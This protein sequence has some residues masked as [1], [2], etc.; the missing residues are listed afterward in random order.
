MTAVVT[1]GE[2]AP[3]PLRS[4]RRLV[5][6]LIGGALVSKLLGF[7]REL[8]MAQVLG[9]SLIADGFRGA[10]TAILLPLAFLQNESV[11]AIM[12]PGQRDALIRGDAPV[13]LASLTMALTLIAVLLTIAVEAAG[14]RWIDAVV[15]GFV[16]EGRDMTLAFVRIMAL[17]MPASVALNCLAA[18]EIAL[19]RSR[20][21]NLRAGLL[22]VCVMLGLVLLMLTGRVDVLAWAFTLSFNAL[23]AWGIWTLWRE[24]QFSFAG[25]RPSLVL[26]AGIDFLRRLR[27]LFALPFVEQLNVWVERLLT[28][29]LGTG[30]VAS[31]DYARTLTDSANMLISQ[32]VGLGVLSTH[33]PE[34]DRARIERI[35]APVLALALPTSMFVVVFAPEIVR[36]VF[37]RGAF[38]EQA[39][40]LTSHALQGIAAGLWASTLGW[41]LLRTL[42]STGR[43]LHAALILIAAHALNIG[44][45]LATASLQQSSGAGVLIIGTGEAVRSLVL[46]GGTLLA[47]SCRRRIAMLILIAAGPALAML[48]AGLLI[49]EEIAGTLPRLAAGGAACAA[50]IA[51][52]ALLLMPATCRAVAVHVRNR[53]FSAGRS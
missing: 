9:A 37:F 29:R 34:D 38:T 44:F 46:L 48:G 36:L 28:S 49:R 41:I 5:A 43:N 47:I 17:G 6:V 45:N 8:L 53:V 35:A 11:P 31:L 33:P 14:I 16:P 15:G 1:D 18:G 40:V 3:R 51:V 26:E 7:A 23:A 21:T 24:G 42:N 10:M 4:T 52:A 32:P 30:T 27:P 20:I 13:R 22:N 2:R 50:A 39:V 19:G 25:A 12:I